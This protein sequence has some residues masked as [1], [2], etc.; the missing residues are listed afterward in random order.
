VEQRR[1]SQLFFQTFVALAAEHYKIIVSD[2]DVEKSG[3]PSDSTIAG[4]A[5]HQ[6]KIIE[7]VKLTLHGEEVHSVYDRLLKPA[8]ITLTE[9][10]QYRAFFK[11]ETRVD[12]VLSQDMTAGYR[13]A[14]RTAVH[15]RLL[16]ERLRERVAREAAVHGET[17]DEAERTMI[18]ELTGVLHPAI[19]D[20]SFKAPDWK[21]LFNDQ[22]T[23]VSRH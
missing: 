3:I 6:R 19:V 22:R 15:R 11:N 5:D 23:I 8:G 10:E 20:S 14:T 2:E 18:R 17:I 4:V 12:A 13:K 16:L 21:G 7:A 1:L 9:F